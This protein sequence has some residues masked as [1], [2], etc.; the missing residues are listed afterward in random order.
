MHSIIATGLLIVMDSFM[1]RWL[2]Y[3]SR[4]I[5]SGSEQSSSANKSNMSFAL[6]ALLSVSE[7]QLEV[8]ENEE[9]ALITR[10]FMRFNDNR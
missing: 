8:L 9:L 2:V 4:T 5:M 6:S 10:R 1:E 7:E 3:S